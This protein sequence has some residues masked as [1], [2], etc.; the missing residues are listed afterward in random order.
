MNK[1]E[2]LTTIGVAAAILISILSLI[3]SVSLTDKANKIA[4]LQ[5][6]PWLIISVKKND[7]TGR[8][9]DIAES[10]GMITWSTTVVVENKGST[11]ANNIQFPKSG[12]VKDLYTTNEKVTL[13]PV[14]IVLGQGQKYLYPI[15]MKSVPKSPGDLKTLLH[16]FQTNDNGV[17]Y[18]FRVKYE[19]L[20][21]NG[22]EYET[23]CGFDIQAKSYKI[24]DNAKFK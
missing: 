11:P 17:F 4:E 20:I 3:Y 14:N 22:E 2:L 5:T 9:Y 12:S 23:E 15:T 1:F 8:Y 21:S 16:Q 18:G 10:N 13:E 7:S 6:R 19:G 24:L